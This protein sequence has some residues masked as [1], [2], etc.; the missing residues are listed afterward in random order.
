MATA[1]I[2]YK[3]EEVTVTKTV[4]KFIL[5]LS[6]RE[7]Q[8]IRELAYRVEGPIQGTYAKVSQAISNALADA[9]VYMPIP[10]YFTGTLR[11]AALPEGEDS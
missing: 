1:K 2:E 9:G 5:E 3:D 6:R 4:E 10:D 8:T 11:G 7:A